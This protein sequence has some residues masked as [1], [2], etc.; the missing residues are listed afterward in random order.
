MQ[1][2]KKRIAILLVSMATAGAER[3]TANLLQHLH[4]EFDFHLV[5]LNPH[6]Q[7][8][9]LPESVPIFALD[10]EKLGHTTRLEKLNNLL[11]MPLLAYRYR[12][13]CQQNGIE[14]SYSMLSRPNFINVLARLM[15]FHGNVIIGQRSAAS[16]LYS[17][18]AWDDRLGRQLI[19]WLYPHADAVV[20]N[21]QAI[22]VD[23]AKNFGLTKPLFTVYNPIDVPRIEYLKTELISVLAHPVNAYFKLNTE[24]KYFEKFTFVSVGRQHPVKNYALILRA[25]AQLNDPT[26]QLIIVGDA[27]QT[28][29]DLPHL[30][31]ALSITDR[32]FFAGFQAN[33]YKFMAKSH[34]FVLASRYEG[35]PNVLLEAMACGVPIVSSDCLSGP[36]ELLA[37]TTDFTKT[38][39]QNADNERAEFG[40]LTPVGNVER[41]AEAMRTMQNDADLR[42]YYV[43]KSR[44]RLTEFQLEGVLTAFRKLFSAKGEHIEPFT[45]I[46]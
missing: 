7:H 9:D 39:P 6:I 13:Y 22:G 31:K 40:I 21:A 18:S 24:G 12:Q 46:N 42:Q 32:V 5:L 29:D 8:L 38:L 36:R 30:A 10:H 25:F 2:P 19:K 15:G 45:D 17:T 33:P 43:E 1:K 4:T 35:F 11:K 14:L 16:S 28:T 26:T 41:L 23:L 20:S 44:E 27:A 34:C 3:V 37:P